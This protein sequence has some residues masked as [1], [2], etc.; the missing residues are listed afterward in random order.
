MEVLSV[1]KFFPDGT[2]ALAPIDLTVAAGEFVTLIGP[3]GCGK[4]TLLK[5]IADLLE[6][7]DGQ[8]CGGA[9]T[10]TSSD[11]TVAASLSF[12]KTRR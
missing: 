9:A 3:S 7:S 5:L 12:F 1:E 6:P 10:V 8:S 2:C 4:S 11:R